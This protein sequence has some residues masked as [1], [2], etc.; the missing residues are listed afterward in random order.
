MFTLIQNEHH[1][2]RGLRLRRFGLFEDRKMNK[3]IYLVT[4]CIKMLIFSGSLKANGIL[5]DEIVIFL[6][7][8]HSRVAWAM[9]FQNGLAYMIGKY[10]SRL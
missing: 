8:T 7:T 10:S 5:L 1:T 4:M 9:S 6:N 2:N 3:Y